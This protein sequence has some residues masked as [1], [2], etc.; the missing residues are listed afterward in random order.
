MNE[1]NF[2]D[3]LWPLRAVGPSV[4]QH[5]GGLLLFFVV[6]ISFIYKSNFSSIKPV[7]GAQ[8]PPLVVDPSNFSAEKERPEIPAKKFDKSFSFFI[9][10]DNAKI[11]ST[12]PS[13]PTGNPSGEQTTSV[14]LQR[15]LKFASFEARFD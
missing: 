7:F 1:S 11:F 6:A 3:F 8:Y 2:I 10:Y 5:P 4:L 15:D 12:K 14:A 13:L 9:Q